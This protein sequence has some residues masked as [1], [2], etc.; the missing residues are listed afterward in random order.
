MIK[1]R[2]LG[3]PNFVSHVLLKLLTNGNGWC[4]VRSFRCNWVPNYILK[5]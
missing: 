4:D 3:S 5:L 2:E 1:W